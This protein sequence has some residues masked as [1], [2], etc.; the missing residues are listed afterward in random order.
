MPW[1]SAGALDA[2]RE[3]EMKSHHNYIEHD[4]GPYDDPPVD[5]DT[6]DVRQALERATVSEAILHSRLREALSLLRAVRR[7]ERKTR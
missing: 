1:I 6:P 3:W 7:E 5:D 2:L 4:P